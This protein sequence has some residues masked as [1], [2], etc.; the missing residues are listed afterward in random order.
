MKL[1]MKE[2][3]K[4]LWK[5]FLAVFVIAFFAINWNQVSWVFNYEAV[6]RFAQQTFG[7]EKS[8]QATSPAGAW[9]DSI[10]EYSSTSNSIEIPEIGVNAPLVV[11]EGLNDT[12][13]HDALNTGVVYYPSSVLPGQIGQ[14]IILG[15]SAPPNWPPIRYD[16]I[17]SK[18][19]DL[20]KGDEIYVYYGNRK[21]TY[22]VT[23]TIFLNRGQEVPTLTNNKSSVIFISCWP[24][25][26]DI[27]RIAVVTVLKT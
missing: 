18:L 21:L 9:L 12:Q 5:P 8:Y 15:H 4:K 19:E 20:S 16:G 14:T 3:I 25:G 6:F 24:P 17:F 7:T 26:H 10:G 27:N 23:D 13:V 1:Q 11:N 22:T 2:Q